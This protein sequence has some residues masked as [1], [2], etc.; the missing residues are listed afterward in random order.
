M[1]LFKAYE[2]YTITRHIGT[3]E[4]EDEDEA[5]KL[6]G[7]ELEENWPKLCVQCAP[8]FGEASYRYL[9]VEEID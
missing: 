3:Y 8:Q 9:E 7:T 5:W 4:T 1:P 6:A 2:T